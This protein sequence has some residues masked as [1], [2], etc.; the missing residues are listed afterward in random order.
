LAYYV[1][2][3][4][5]IH[6]PKTYLNAKPTLVGNDNIPPFFDSTTLL[7]ID[8]SKHSYV[9]NHA[10]CINSAHLLEVIDFLYTNEAKPPTLD[11][12]IIINFFN[13]RLLVKYN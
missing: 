12:E 3:I 1:R 2:A 7:N 9:G 10:N 13:L 5:C 11:A 4:L 6:A 8:L